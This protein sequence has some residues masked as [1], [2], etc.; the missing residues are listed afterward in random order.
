M[1]LI[2][3]L[4]LSACGK[5]EPNPDFTDTKNILN[6]QEFFATKASGSGVF[7]DYAD[8]AYRHFYVTFEGE[9][10]GDDFFLTEDFVWSDGEK[11]QRIWHLV[12]Q[13]DKNFT[14]TA[15]DVVGIAKGKLLN[16][17]LHMLYTL[18]VKRENGDMIDLNMDDRMYLTEKN[19]I[20]NR[21]K[22]KKYGITVGELVATFSK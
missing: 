11:Q 17:S 15:D 20:I 12:F 21:A 18:R 22:A 9:K 6:I 4:L 3:S 16:N 19:V 13:D 8:K 10:K 7:F 5:S 14:G 2:S 1:S